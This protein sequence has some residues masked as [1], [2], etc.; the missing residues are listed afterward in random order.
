M[1]ENEHLFAHHT[2]SESD[3]QDLLNGF[4]PGHPYHR[5]S[6]WESELVVGELADHETMA[7][8]IARAG[9]QPSV[10]QA[11]KNGWDRPV[12]P[13]FSQHR[14]GKKRTLVTIVGPY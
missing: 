14:V 5:P 10:S 3:R 7:H 6:D 2:V 8:V 13:G 9:L 1:S 11:R 4:P 12:P